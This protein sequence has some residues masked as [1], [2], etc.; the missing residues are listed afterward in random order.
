MFP[1]LETGTPE[2]S[3]MSLEFEQFWLSGPW[4]KLGKK[5]AERHFNASVKTDEDRERIKRARDNYATDL[6][7]NHWKPPQHGSTWFNNWKDF[8]D[9]EMKNESVPMRVEQALP[10]NPHYDKDGRFQIAKHVCQYCQVIH[11]HVCE[12]FTCQFQEEKPCPA[13]IERLQAK[14]AMV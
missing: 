8:V 11:E 2:G 6:K 10:R 9:M 12:D 14:R 1:Q 13:F 7:V 3:R 5:A 4:Q